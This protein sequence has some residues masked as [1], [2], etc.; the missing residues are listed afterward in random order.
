MCRSSRREAKSEFPSRRL[1]SKGRAKHQL[2]PRQWQKIDS[3][4]IF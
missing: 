1:R 3:L 4:L 2:W